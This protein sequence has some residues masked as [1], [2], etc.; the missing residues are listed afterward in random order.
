[1][2]ERETGCILSNKGYVENMMYDLPKKWGQIVF[3]KGRE[4]DLFKEICWSP[5]NYNMFG[6]EAI[7]SSIN[8]G[9]KF[10]GASNSKVDIIDIDTSKDLD[11]VKDI[12]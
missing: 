12:I 5:Q 1:M 9:G 2:S 6:F 7:N 10:L 8:M 4:L 11:K 3:L